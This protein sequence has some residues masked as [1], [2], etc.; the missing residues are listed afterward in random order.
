MLRV[1]FPDYHGESP[2]LLAILRRASGDTDV[3]LHC[4][5]IAKCRSISDP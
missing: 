4:A 1:S 2:P 3:P 5:R